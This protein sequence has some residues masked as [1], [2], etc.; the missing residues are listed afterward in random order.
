MEMGCVDTI[1]RSI[2]VGNAKAPRVANT[3]LKKGFAK[4]A[5]DQQYVN[6]TG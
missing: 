2:R 5:K 3:G 6:T 4:G 1:K